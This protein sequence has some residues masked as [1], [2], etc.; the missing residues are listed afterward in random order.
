M[1]KIRWNVVDNFNVKRKALKDKSKET[2]TDVPKMLPSTT[3]AKCN[4]AT[5]VHAYQ[6]FGDSKSNL[7]Y[8]IC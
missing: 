7:S 2:A 8:I 6:V 4:D 3:V 5:N 1:A